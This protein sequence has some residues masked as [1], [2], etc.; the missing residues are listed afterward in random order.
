MVTKS[1]S[2]MIEEAILTLGER[3][4]SSRQGIW[5]A[6]NGK[7]ADSDYK[8]F[9]LRLK[10]MKDSGMIAQTKGSF[11]LQQ[12]YK[13]KLLKALENGKS[14]A[15][16]AAGG[17]SRVTTKKSAKKSTKKVATKKS[18]KQATRA[19]KSGAVAKRSSAAKKSNAK[20]NAKKGAAMAK[21]GNPSKKTAGSKKTQDKKQDKK[22]LNTKKAA[23]NKAKN[24]RKGAA[25]KK[26]TGKRGKA[27]KGGIQSKRKQIAV[28]NGHDEDQ[29]DS[30]DDAHNQ[31]TPKPDAGRLA[32]LMSYI[33]MS[34][35][36]L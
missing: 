19:R 34:N 26:G 23:A 8:H 9:V 21:K 7:Y 2:E 27:A 25:A 14:T 16:V 12:S 32:L 22:T 5:K 35:G 6:V 28:A 33:S 3:G 13:L 1:Y 20:K 15:S 17:K 4:G 30:H 24:S 18:K 10:K 11:R 31:G 36:I 29:K